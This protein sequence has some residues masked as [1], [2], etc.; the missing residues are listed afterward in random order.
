MKGIK[1][2]SWIA[3]F[4]LTN[5]CLAQN[6]CQQIKEI[7]QSDYFSDLSK[8]FI[9]LCSSV[10]LSKPIKDSFF[11]AFGKIAHDASSYRDPLIIKPRSLLMQNFNFC[12]A[13]YAANDEDDPVNKKALDNISVT[14]RIRY[15]LYGMILEITDS[16]FGLQFKTAT[17]SEFPVSIQEQFN[18]HEKNQLPDADSSTKSIPLNDFGY[19]VSYKTTGSDFSISIINENINKCVRKLIGNCNNILAVKRLDHFCLASL[20]KDGII[21]IWNIDPLL[22]PLEIILINKIQKVA[23]KQKQIILHQEW[24]EILQKIGCKNDQFLQ[25][26]IF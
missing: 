16:K 23:D 11:E 10:D 17:G 14:E 2:L 19:T 15:G 20:T 1:V 3:L 7:V 21:K 25:N 8:N 18:N 22:D 6:Y 12:I 13:T 5:S 4:C 26:I 9:E 24:E